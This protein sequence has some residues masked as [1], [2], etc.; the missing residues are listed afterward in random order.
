[1]AVDRQQKL[2]VG[3]KLRNFVLALIAK[4]LGNSGFHRRAFSRLSIRAL[5]LDHRQRNPVDKTHDIRTACLRQIRAQ[6]TE[7]FRE[8]KTVVL[9]VLPVDEGYGRVGLA[10]VDKLGDGDAE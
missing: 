7:F 6:D 4:S 1:M 2:A 9:R 8:R 5:G 10:S 3:E